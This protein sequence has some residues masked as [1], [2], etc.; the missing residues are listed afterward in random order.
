MEQQLISLEY[1][2]ALAENCQSSEPMSLELV[3][4]V[5]KL[6]AAYSTSFDK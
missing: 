5:D 1:V 3:K 2:H 6:T 4:A